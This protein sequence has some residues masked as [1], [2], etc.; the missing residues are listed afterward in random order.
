EAE[1][2]H[3]QLKPHSKL[4]KLQFDMDFA[5]IAI[6]GRSAKGNIVTKYPIKRIT[7]KSKGVSTLSGRK[8]WFDPILHRLNVDERGIYLGEF[9]GEDRIAV[10]NL[11]GSYELTTYELTNHYASD[12]LLVEKFN[13]DH[14]Y[15]MVHKDG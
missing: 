11:D 8:I 1:I 3:V 10:V 6:K 7:L 12:I 2:V 14:V 13:P 9:D 15:T 4:R 5:E